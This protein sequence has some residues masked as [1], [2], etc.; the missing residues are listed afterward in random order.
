MASSKLGASL[1]RSVA[2]AVQRWKKVKGAPF[3]YDL[4][5]LHGGIEGARPGADAFVLGLL[6]GFRV[7]LSV[8]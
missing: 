5:T 6:A 8:I 1:L 7:R 4:L 2:A 3:A